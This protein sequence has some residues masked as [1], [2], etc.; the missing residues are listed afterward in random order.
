MGMVNVARAVGLVGLGALALLPPA[1]LAGQQLDAPSERIF[2]WVR[3]TDGRRLEGYLRWDRNETHWADF[4]DGRKEISRERELE[5]ERLD[6]ELRVRRRTERSV[7]LPS[8]RI[9]WDEDDG[10]PL[11]TTAAAVRFAHL[12]A[13]AVTGPRR[14][15]AVLTTGDTLELVAGSSDL[16]GGFRGLVVESA[17][18]DT[19]EL[20]WDEFVR[21]DF[22]SA[23]TGWAPPRS[24]R[25]FG[26]LRTQGGQELTGL[27]AWDLDEAL[28]TDVLD[29]E[30][31]R[32]DVRI[33][34]S[35]IT[36]IS[37]ESGS[38]ARVTRASGAQVVLEDTNDV[39]ASNRG[40]EVTDAV[41]G[42]V[43][44]DWDHFASIRFHAPDAAS[45]GR[46]AFTAGGRLRGAAAG[47]GG[48]TASGLVRWDIADEYGWDVLEA[49]GEGLRLTVELERVL[50]IAKGTTS[51]RVALVD[52]RV[53]DVDIDQTDNGDFRRAN[54]GVFVEALSGASGAAV[55]VPWRDLLTVTFER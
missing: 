1:H 42:R 26:T 35:D 37:R 32:E 31:G 7:T 51:A 49:T 39:D 23:P 10:V 14:A 15:V 43:V 33:P 13:L 45:G 34:F 20:D 17:A 28:A 4:L 48:T 54:R 46:D 16:G 30:Q 8:V 19:V 55:M 22:A 50:S 41:F 24:R 12:S 38:S 36:A 18:G 3:T 27:V 25:L 40:I 21:V 47:A 52:G 29:G 5:A 9:T 6:E 2:G 53:L 44:V 11:E